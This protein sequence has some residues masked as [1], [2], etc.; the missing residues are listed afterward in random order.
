MTVELIRRAAENRRLDKESIQLYRG[1]QKN[2]PYH[3]RFFVT[4]TYAAIPYSGT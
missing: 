2:G 1:C 4:N 3:E